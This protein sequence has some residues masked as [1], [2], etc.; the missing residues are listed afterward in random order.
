M[1]ATWVAQLVKRPTLGFSPG[2]DLVVMGWS[3]ASGGLCTQC[4]LLEIL[5]SS[6]SAPSHSQALFLFLSIK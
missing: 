3:P 5:F 1:M 2:H 4:S 6:P